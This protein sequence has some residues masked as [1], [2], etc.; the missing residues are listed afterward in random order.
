MAG[1]LRHL[2]VLLEDSRKPIA[3]LIG[4]DDGSMMERRWH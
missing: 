2:R 1:D 3:A 4:W